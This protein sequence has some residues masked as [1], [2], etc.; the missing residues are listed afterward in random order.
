MSEEQHLPVWAQRFAAPTLAFPAWSNDRPDRL[1]F[2]CDDGG[3]MQVWMLDLASGERRALT[4]QAVGVEEFVVLPGGTG[5]AWWSDDTGDEFGS[6]VATDIDAG[7]SRPLFEG[8][9]TGWSQ[10]LALAHPVAAAALADGLSYRVFVE[11]DGDGHPRLVAE[12]SSPIGL[13]REWATTSGGLSPDG[14]LLCLRHTDVGD[15]LHFGLRVLD[16][17]SGDVVDDRV[18]VGLNLK[19]ADWSPVLGDQRVALVHE[20]DGLDRPAVWSPL[21]GGLRHYPLAL[22]G[23]TDV[24]GWWPD[25]SALLLLHQHDGCDTLHRLDLDSGRLTWSLDPQGTITGARVRPDGEVWLRDESATRAPRIRSARGTVIVSPLGPAPSPGRPH[26]SMT[27]A[28]PGGDAH[29][30]VATPVGEPPY[31]TVMVVHGGPEWHFS[32]DLDPWEQALL[33][34]G[35]AVA[36]VNYRGST[37]SSVAWRT[38]LHDGNI[39]FPEVEDVLA[40]MDHLVAV[41]VSDPTRFGIEGRSWGGY[42]TLLAVGLHPS[43]FAAAVAVVPVADSLLTHEDCS[44]PQKAYDIAI[45]GGSPSE[46]PERYIERSPATYVDHVDTPLLVIAGEHDSACPIRQVRSYVDRLKARDA[47]VELVVY[48]AGHHANAKADQIEHAERALTF[49]CSRLGLASHA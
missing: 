38:S 48:D 44:P 29:V 20:R 47:D 23:P 13:G 31:P 43:R 21:T 46:V 5:V 24:L 22:P 12:S 26:T 34:Y 45:M 42:V 25:A 33:D 18:D 41:G 8:L 6:W 7:T 9:P 27:V 36:K 14:T 32:D 10:G 49:L 39:G 37:G 16:V 35:M 4:D 3:V 17:A 15:I 19:V 28:T 2:V 1:F 11:G 30:L 40:T